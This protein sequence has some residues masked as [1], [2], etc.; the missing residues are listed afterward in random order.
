M[1]G[2]EDA[3][4]HQR[5]LAGKSTFFSGLFSY[6]ES[7]IR[8]GFSI[9]IFDYQRLCIKIQVDD[10]GHDKGAIPTSDPVAA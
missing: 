1:V 7:P 2:T 9:A 4:D 3:L 10:L 8:R 5:W 6:Y